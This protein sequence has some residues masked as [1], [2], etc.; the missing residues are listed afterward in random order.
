MV[1]TGVNREQVLI[2]P[3]EVDNNL[4]LALGSHFH[5]VPG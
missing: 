2:H 3:P 1:E 4:T 5:S